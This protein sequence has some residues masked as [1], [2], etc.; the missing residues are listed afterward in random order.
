MCHV[1]MMKVIF[2]FIFIFRLGFKLT[3]VQPVAE[4][5]LLLALTI[6]F[7]FFCPEGILWVFEKLSDR[8]CANPFDEQKEVTQKR[9]E[10]C[11]RHSFTLRVHRMLHALHTFSLRQK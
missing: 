1:F 6:F 5:R 9:R 4:N 10:E 8:I 2:I 3:T 11:R 7:F